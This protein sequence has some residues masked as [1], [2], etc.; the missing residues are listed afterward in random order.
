MF[1]S[2]LLVSVITQRLQSFYAPQ[3]ITV[4]SKKVEVFQS[5]KELKESDVLK[6][7][8]V[9]EKLKVRGTLKSVLPNHALHEIDRTPISI[10]LYHNFSQH[11]LLYSCSGSHPFVLHKFLHSGKFCAVMNIL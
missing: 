3:L 7:I 11:I 9:F 1:F 10:H 6:K 4:K 8:L 5:F 2:C